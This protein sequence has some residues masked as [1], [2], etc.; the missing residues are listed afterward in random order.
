[1]RTL[2]V[3]PPDQIFP[4]AAIDESCDLPIRVALED[5]ARARLARNKEHIT[6]FHLQGSRRSAGTVPDQLLSIP[7]NCVHKI[8]ASG[9]A[10]DILL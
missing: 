9:V 7:L 1:M 8:G 3:A 6:G 10:A 4:F 2:R 5:L